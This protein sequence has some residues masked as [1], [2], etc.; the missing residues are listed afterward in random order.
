M[1]VCCRNP[2]NEYFTLS[3][4][5]CHV[6]AFYINYKLKCLQMY[7][8]GNHIICL[9]ALNVIIFLKILEDP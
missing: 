9:E 8:L 1:I 4:I 2:G 3:L 6:M 5:W 7:T